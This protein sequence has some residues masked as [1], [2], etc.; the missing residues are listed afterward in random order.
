M[1]NSILVIWLFF[2]LSTSF[3]QKIKNYPH[4]ILVETKNYNDIDF[5]KIEKE[6]AQTQRHKIKLTVMKTVTCNN[7]CGYSTHIYS[8]LGNPNNVIKSMKKYCLKQASRT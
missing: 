2:I 1:K 5:E 7:A 4:E 3:G 8:F 6:V